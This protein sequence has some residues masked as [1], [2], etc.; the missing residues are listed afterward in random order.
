MLYWNA[1]LD[2]ED[3]IIHLQEELNLSEEKV[4]IHVEALPSFIDTRVTLQV[5]KKQLESYPKEIDFVTKN[6]AILKL[7]KDAGFDVTLPN[8][9]SSPVTSEH[10]VDEVSTDK[11]VLPSIL[12]FN[13]VEEEKVEVNENIT[14]EVK[15]LNLNNFSTDNSGFVIEESEIEEVEELPEYEVE[16]ESISFLKVKDVA[17]KSDKVKEEKVVIKKIDF[18]SF[19]QFSLKTQLPHT[20]DNGDF[21]KINNILDNIVEDDLDQLISNIDK[22]K[23]NINE[24]SVPIFIKK[25]LRTLVASG[26]CC[27]IVFGFTGYL[28]YIP[29]FAYKIN[30]KNNS[31]LKQEIIA[32]NPSTIKEKLLNL[33]IYSEQQLPKQ[34]KDF[35]ERSKGSIVIYSTGANSCTLTNGS[36]LVNSGEKYYRVLPN[37]IYGP[38][39]IIKPYSQSSPS[40]TFEVEA[41]VKGGEQNIEKD[42]VLNLSTIGFENLSRSCFAKTTTG[43]NDFSSSDNSIVTQEVLD[44]LKDYSEKAI[45]Q[46]LKEEVEELGKK[47]IYTKQEWIDKDTSQNLFNAEVGQSKE[48]VTLNRV[49]TKKVKYLSLDAVAKLI[50]SNMNTQTKEVKN[51]KIKNIANDGTQLK[52]EVA[53]DLVEKSKIDEGKIKELLNKNQGSN[54]LEEILQKEYPNVEKVQQLNEGI[55]LPVFKKITVD[56]VDVF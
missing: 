22:I 37:L 5:F 19:A 20:V 52:A 8:F 27:F 14:V 56:I 25:P 11:R 40:I 12:S 24:N 36:F 38:N 44:S 41:L 46:K 48:L 29:A 28:N 18:D 50:E 21:A 6:L 45:E 47:N 42:T 23:I 35:F 31:Q 30:V 43:V 15:K 55:N 34:K 49:E 2:R 17:I 32:I 16:E 4:L 53:F 13:F 3:V 33:S 9:G 10:E 1:N 7:L 54:N 26:F 51:V 39:V